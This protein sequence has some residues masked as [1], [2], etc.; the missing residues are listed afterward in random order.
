M[1]VAFVGAEEFEI[2]GLLAR[3]WAARAA[4]PGFRAARQ[5]G[6]HLI[7]EQKPDALASVGI[8]GALAPDLALGEI[9][10]DE[11]AAPRCDRPHRRGA[12]VSIDRVIATAEEKQ[13]LAALGLVVEME[14]RAVA[15]LAREHGLR[16]FCVKAV[17]D[18]AAED[19]PLDFNRYRAADGRFEKRRIAWTAVARPLTLLPALMRLNRHSQFAARRLGEFLADCRFE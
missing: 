11:T 6:E 10:V 5:A 12:V 8:C 15:E 3:G 9:V 4:G 1:K 7:R 14:S 19:L 13:R 18:T 2:R 17:S 16:F